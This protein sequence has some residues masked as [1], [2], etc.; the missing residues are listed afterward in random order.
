[1][2]IEVALTETPGVLVDVQKQK[3]AKLLHEKFCSMEICKL[4]WCGVKVCKHTDKL[5]QDRAEKLLAFATKN[6]VALSELEA[7]FTDF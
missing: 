6:N 5:W 3:L 7:F 2:E 1:M 4:N